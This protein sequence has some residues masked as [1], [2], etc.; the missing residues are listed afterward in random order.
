MIIWQAL[1]M[2]LYGSMFDVCSV[3]GRCHEN[4]RVGGMNMAIAA[5]AGSVCYAYVCIHGYVCMDNLYV[6]AE[7]HPFSLRPKKLLTHP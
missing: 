7:A 1:E 6:N 2:E 3:Q 5:G 4:G